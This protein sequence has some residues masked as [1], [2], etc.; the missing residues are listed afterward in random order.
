MNP[1]EQPALVIIGPGRLGRSLAAR[2]MLLGWATDLRGRNSALDPLPPKAIVLLTVAD[3][4]IAALCESLDVDASHTVAHCS[5]LLSAE[6]L[7]SAKGQ[8]AVTGSAHP[9]QSF[10]GEDPERFD[11]CTWFVEAEQDATQALVELVT[12]LGGIPRR[13]AGKQKTLYHASAVLAC[14]HL[15]ALMDA[16][17]TAGDHAGLARNELWPALHP[18]VQATLDT[19]ANKGPAGALT[20]P[21]ARGDRVT[22]DAHMQALNASDPKLAELYRALSSWTESLT[23][24]R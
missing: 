23:T 11:S 17:L 4:D 14:N 12:Q 19:I 3:R 10:A 20:G 8:G 7:V 21:V 24:E 22:V 1:V 2:A 13:I 15:C 18:L 5:G 16:A 9:L 6:V